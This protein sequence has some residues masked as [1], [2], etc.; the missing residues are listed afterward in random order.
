MSEYPTL[1]ETT[2]HPTLGPGVSGVQRI[3]SALEMKWLRYH[4]HNYGE[5]KAPRIRE[6]APFLLTC[7]MD[8]RVT[9][10]FL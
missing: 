2:S 6:T 7:D 3:T 9:R 8:I 10:Y 1:S 5:L 4:P